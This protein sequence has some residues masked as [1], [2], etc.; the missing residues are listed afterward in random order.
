M[1]IESLSAVSP[2]PPEKG[3]A[4]DE[5]M[6]APIPVITL[7]GRMFVQSRPDLA[8]SSF[9][10]GTWEWVATVPALQQD[11]YVARVSTVADSSTAGTNHS[12]FVLTAHTTT[13]SIWYVSEPDS[14]WSVDNIAPEAPAGFAVAYNTGSGNHLTWDPSPAEDFHYFRVYRSSDP[15]F[16]PSPA[17]IVHSTTD[18]EW[19]DPDFDGWNVYYKITALDY[20]ENES[21]PASAG[22]VTDADPPVLPRSFALRQNVPNPFNPTTRIRFDLPE[23]AGVRLVIYDVSGRKIRELASGAMAAGAREVTWDGRDAAGRAA[24]SGIYFYRLDAGRF[25]QTRK[26][27]LLR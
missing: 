12:V 7:Q 5:V 2:E 20:V 4:G 14:G 26:M 10:P 8:A 6:I 13:P 24:A 9:P 18:T 19:S 21:A 11:A 25:T 15:D 27:I 1:L 17:C 23:A 3:A 22:T 16:V